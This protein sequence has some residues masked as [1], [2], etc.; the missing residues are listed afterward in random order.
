M[1]LGGKILDIFKKLI[2]FSVD[3]QY[4]G[5]QYPVN[6]IIIPE[7]IKSLI[8]N[9]QLFCA[10]SHLPMIVPPNPYGKKRWRGYLSNG[11]KFKISIF[12]EKLFY[13]EQSKILDE[14]IVYKIVN[15]IASVPYNFTSKIFT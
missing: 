4:R 13:D 7:A 11:I 8:N 10:P 5:E 15:S 9:I 6:V 3:L 14:N 12:T 2:L 1:E